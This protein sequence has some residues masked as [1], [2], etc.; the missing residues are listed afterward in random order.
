MKIVFFRSR[1]DHE[2]IEFIEKNRALGLCSKEFFDSV[3]PWRII[4]SASYVVFEHQAVPK[5]Q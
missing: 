1:L 4:P 2:Q 5:R 3:G